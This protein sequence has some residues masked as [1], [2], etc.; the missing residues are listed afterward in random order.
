M[1]AIAAASCCHLEDSAPESLGPMPSASVTPLP[2]DHLAPGELAEGKEDAFG[3][4]LP[5][6]FHVVAR[7]PDSVFADSDVSAEFAA[8]YLRRHIDAR[9]VE[10][11]PNST[12]FAGAHPKNQLPDAG[13]RVLKVEVQEKWRGSQIVVR[14]ETPAPTVPGLSEEERWRREGLSPKGEVLDPTHLQ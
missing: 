13:D 6:A 3:V 10:I 7:F 14:D 11:G 1:A 8:N 9:H 4:I 12:I 5:R 2:I